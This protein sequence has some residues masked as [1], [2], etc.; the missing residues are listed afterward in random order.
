ML[1]PSYCNPKFYTVRLDT[2]ERQLTE[3]YW[4]ADG[5]RFNWQKVYQLDAAGNIIREATMDTLGGFKEGVICS[6]PQIKIAYDQSQNPEEI[7]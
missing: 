5:T 3:S 6:A 1:G 2:L 7:S 4:R